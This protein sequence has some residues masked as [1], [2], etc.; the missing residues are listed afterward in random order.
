VR[1]E[2]RRGK[3]QKEMGVESSILSTFLYSPTHLRQVEGE[4]KAPMEKEGTERVMDGTRIGIF[5]RRKNSKR[6]NRK[7][8]RGEGGV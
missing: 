6:N 8:G 3:N 2:E 7:M 1:R 4:I 5:Y